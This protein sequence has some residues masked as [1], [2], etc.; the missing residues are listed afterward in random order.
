MEE[1]MPIDEEQD[2]QL[3]ERSVGTGLFADFNHARATASP[4]KLSA[5]EELARYYASPKFADP[6]KF[7]VNN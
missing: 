2:Q 3:E 1:S 7:W 5:T 6:I 4:F